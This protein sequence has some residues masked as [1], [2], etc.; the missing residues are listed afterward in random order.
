MTFTEVRIANGM[1]N[2]DGYSKN[3]TLKGAIKDL[4][5]E[6]AKYNREEAEALIS[7][8]D[9]TVEEVRTG[10]LNITGEYYIEATPVEGASRY[11]FLNGD[12]E[13]YSDEN[14][15]I[16]YAARNWYLYIRFLL[17]DEKIAEIASEVT[18][19]IKDYNKFN[20]S[21]NERELKNAKTQLQQKIKQCEKQGH[22][23]Q[24]TYVKENL[25]EDEL[26]CGFVLNGIQQNIESLYSILKGTLFKLS[27]ILD[28]EASKFDDSV[29]TMTECHQILTRQYYYKNPEKCLY[30]IKVYKEIF[31]VLDEFKKY[32]EFETT[33]SEYDQFRQEYL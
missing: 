8:L 5:R 28:K 20:V 2:L 21:L 11:K 32:E 1:V 16:E 18:T 24:L 10:M 26:I 9:E 31:V 3:K 17:P 33:A 25:F 14:I 29:K 7:Y 23:L 30:F 12:E 27:C 4:S 15:E 13:D 6:V 19:L 22:K